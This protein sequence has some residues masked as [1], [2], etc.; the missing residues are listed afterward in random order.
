MNSGF[1]IEEANGRENENL[2]QGAYAKPKAIPFVGCFEQGAN[3]PAHCKAKSRQRDRLM[4]MGDMH[5]IKEQQ[6]QRH[7]RKKCADVVDN[8][9][10]S[11][12][13]CMACL[14]VY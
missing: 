2:N 6:Y 13:S 10:L 11:L 12:V 3:E 1:D 9:S 5:C 7:I 14:N 8:R 4:V